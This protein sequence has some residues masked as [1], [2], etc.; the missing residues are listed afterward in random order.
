MNSLE[1]TTQLVIDLIKKNK[2]TDF[3]FSVGKSTGVSTAVRLSKV[4]T[5]QYHLDNS[6]ML[7]SI[8]ARIKVKLQV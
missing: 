5:L 2:A 8:L 3:E 1:K 6:L 7:V 4:E